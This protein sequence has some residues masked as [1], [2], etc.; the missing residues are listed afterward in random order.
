MGI[1]FLIAIALI[2]LFLKRAIIQPVKTMALLSNKISTGDLDLQ[3]NH[4]SQDEIG[5][6]A[7]SLN[8]MVESLKMAL[9][10]IEE[11]ED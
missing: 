10:M 4:N 3:F 6:L 2:N 9:Q 7:K 5:S 8:R 1:I 11:E